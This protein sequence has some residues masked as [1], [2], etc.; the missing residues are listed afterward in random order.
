MVFHS[1]SSSPDAFLLTNFIL[2]GC[3]HI[4]IFRLDGFEDAVEAAPL[5]KELFQPEYFLLRVVYALGW[6]LFF[7]AV[8]PLKA[9]NCIK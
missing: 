2:T 9:V 6:L 8:L 3:L 1:L 7:S 5:F 4:N